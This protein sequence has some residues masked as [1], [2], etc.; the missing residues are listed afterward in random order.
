M[1]GVAWWPLGAVAAIAGVLV[2]GPVEDPAR[3]E[4][5]G[6]PLMRRLNL[7]VA[8]AIVLAGVALLPVWRPIE[9]GLDAP[10]GV[11]GNAP[12]GITAA[13]RATAG[14]DDRLFNP[15]PWGS[16]FEF[17]LPDLPVAIDSRIELF[18]AA[19]WDTYENIVA[20]GEGWAAQLDDWG[21]T[22]IVVGA[23]ETAMADRLTA[24][25][26]RIDLHGRGRLDVRRLRTDRPPS[27]STRRP[28]GPSGFG[29]T[30][31]RAGRVQP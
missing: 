24:A 2:T 7:V 29:A 15:Q 17:A 1:R 4:P 22:M 21:V 3:P 16:W 11:V 19:T 25:G 10:A 6:S 23:K 27:S 20:G 8:G 5:Q 18:P 12:P 30:P 14:P 13:L 9:P 28:P 31:H 26:W